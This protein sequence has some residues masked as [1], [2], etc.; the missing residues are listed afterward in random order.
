[1]RQAG[2]ENSSCESSHYNTL[3]ID[4]HMRDTMQNRESFRYSL[5]AVVVKEQ[6]MD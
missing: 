6:E 2:N 1:V 5:P 3:S 4:L